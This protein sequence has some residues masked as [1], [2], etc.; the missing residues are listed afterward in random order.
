MTDA[1]K[2]VLLSCF[3]IS[4]C[5][6]TISNFKQSINVELSMLKATPTE[7]EHHIQYYQG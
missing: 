4:T 5:Q 7:T 2:Y 6:L 1:G 3:V